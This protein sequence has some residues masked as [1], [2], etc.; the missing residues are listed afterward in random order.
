MFNRGTQLRSR[1]EGMKKM[2]AEIAKV[3][4]RKKIAEE[5]STIVD[6]MPVQLLVAPEQRGINRLVVTLISSIKKI[7]QKE[8]I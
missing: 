2:D 7:F 8:K 3:E 5:M 6:K 4:A 1:A